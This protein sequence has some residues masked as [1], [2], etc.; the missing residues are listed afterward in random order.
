MLIAKQKEGP[1]RL[2]LWLFVII[3]LLI[4]AAA[5]YALIPDRVRPG[6]AMEP[7]E[8]YLNNESEMRINIRDDG[9]GLEKIRVSVFQD[10]KRR[11]LVNREFGGILEHMPVQNGTKWSPLDMGHASPGQWSTKLSVSEI[12]LQ[13]GKFRIKVRARDGSWVNLLRGNKA[14]VERT[15]VLDRTAPRIR[16]ES[17]RNNLTRGGS[18][19]VAFRVEGKARRVGVSVGDNFFPAYQQKSGLHLALYAYPYDIA[20]GEKNPV[21]EAR[22]RA[23]NTDS[24][25]L[26]CYVN[27]RE[28]PLEKI[29][30]NSAFL[31]ETLPAF[32][33]AYPGITNKVDLFQAVNKRMRQRNRTKLQKIGR[34]TASHPLWSGAFLRQPGSARQSS[35]AVKRFYYHDSRKMSR[36]IHSGIDL[37]SSPRALVPAANTG[38][39]VYADR[40]GIYGKTAIIDH[41]LGLQ[42]LYG[43]LSRIRVD[44]GQRV[45]KG[46]VI[47]RTGSTGLA[48]GDHL[49]FQMMISGI[50]VDPVEWWDE[51]WIRLHIRPKLRQ[52]V[53]A[54]N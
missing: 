26:R 1:S 41:G 33:E 18:G 31:T 9:A 28:I 24:A 27:S 30:L 44:K 35:F 6:I 11:I 14:S 39:V 19:A 45:N 13:A 7:G 16:L 36:A 50:P 38:R 51:D 32:Q 25:T 22:D 29:D 54:K 2:R 3:L 42:T 46:K 4:G 43:H 5:C 21:L 34:N 8:E 48:G 10:G 17:F 20:A 47:G 23:G 49:H 40:L 12:N 37:A 53:P 52:A 15:Y